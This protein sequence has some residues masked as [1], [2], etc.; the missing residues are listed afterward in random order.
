MEQNSG[1]EKTYTRSEILEALTLMPHHKVAGANQNYKLED[2][3]SDQK[4]LAFDNLLELLDVEAE[5]LPRDIHPEGKCWQCHEIPTQEEWRIKMRATY[6][7]AG[8]K[9]PESLAAAAPD[10]PIYDLTEEEVL[11]AYKALS[12]NGKFVRRDEVGEYFG[13]PRHHGKLHRPLARLVKA[14]LIEEKAPVGMGIYTARP[15]Q[16]ATTVS[17]N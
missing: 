16:E 11:A 12:T 4:A 8:V 7:W 1:D 5:D 2:I 10:S 9:I 3:T 13:L 6:D 15:A 17:D 14:G